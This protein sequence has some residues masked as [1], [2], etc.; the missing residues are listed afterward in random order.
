MAD[1]NFI[2]YLRVSTVRQGVSGLGLEAG[3]KKRRF[4]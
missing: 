4:Y 1:G 3:V 2:S